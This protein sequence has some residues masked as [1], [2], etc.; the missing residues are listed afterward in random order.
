MLLAIFLIIIFC[1]TMAETMA[2]TNMH[3]VTN[4]AYEDSGKG[5]VINYVIP[6]F[7]VHCAKL[8]EVKVV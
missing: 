3:D 7:P 5:N 6:S 4:N 8:V 2:D 1:S